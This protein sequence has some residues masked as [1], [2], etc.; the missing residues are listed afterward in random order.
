MLRT[1]LFRFFLLSYKVNKT[2]STNEFSEIG[3]LENP[4]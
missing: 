2:L 3:Q 1:D 4:F